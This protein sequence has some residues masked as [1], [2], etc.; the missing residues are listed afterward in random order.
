MK[1]RN[2]EFAATLTNAKKDN[3]LM[4]QDLSTYDAKADAKLGITKLCDDIQSKID[5]KNEYD[6]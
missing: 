2:Y 4:R 1:R 5:Y 6:V 3:I